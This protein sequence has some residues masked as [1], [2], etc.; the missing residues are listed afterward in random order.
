MY[1]QL[2]CFQGTSRISLE[3]SQIKVIVV[4]FLIHKTDLE[5]DRKEVMSFHR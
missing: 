4:Y 3:E 2:W 5:K 1:F